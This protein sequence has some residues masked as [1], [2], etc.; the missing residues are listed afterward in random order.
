[1]KIFHIPDT[2][3]F[4]NLVDKSQGNVMLHLPDGSQVNLKQNHD[5]Q[6]IFQMMRPDPFGLHISLSNAEDVSAFMQ[7]MM[8]SN[9]SR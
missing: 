8:E 9:V 5:A 2:N 3:K 1:M 6:Q 7:Y 4:L